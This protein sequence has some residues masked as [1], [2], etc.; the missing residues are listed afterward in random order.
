[1][2]KPRTSLLIVAAAGTFAGGGLAI[3]KYS[4]AYAAGVPTDVPVA[5]TG[6]LTDNGA[7]VT[8]MRTIGI[9][10]YATAAA[11]TPLC[12]ASSLDTPV[13]AG[14]F[15]RTFEA[16]C[17]QSL[18]TTATDPHVEVFVA[19]ASVGGRIRIGAVPYAVE[20]LSSAHALDGVPVGGIIDWWRPSGSTALPPAGF[21]VCDG[22]QV[23]DAA[24]PYNGMT[25]PDLRNR[26]T[27]G[28][29]LV[30][31]IGTT[32][33]AASHT[34]TV[35][36]GSHTHTVDLN[37]DHPSASAAALS[38]GSHAHTVLTFDGIDWYGGNG[39]LV[40]DWNNGFTQPAGSG[41]Y[42]MWAGVAQNV[43]SSSA[44]AHTHNVDL[45]A[46]GTTLVSS[47]SVDLPATT[48]SS[49]SNLPPYV[50]LLKIVRIK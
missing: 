10:L 22:S 43:V 19:G 35:D 42:P 36:L 14:H 27:Y 28:A 41:F 20:S 26:F 3:Y 29:N 21:V 48:S 2:N 45:P 17:N 47:S 49:S 46:L 9:S 7:P 25:V 39:T 38:A 50:G 4:R 15:H 23:N 12:Q 34:H 40:G 37:H 11:S 6:Y 8:G 16:A 1:M 5:Y 32:G 13:T 24:S 31:D 44:G 30:T 18:L 33:G